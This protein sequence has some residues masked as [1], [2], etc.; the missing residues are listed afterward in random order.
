M[1]TP[2]TEFAFAI[3]YFTGSKIFNTLM[4][5]RAVEMGY[6]MNEHGIYH[7]ENKKKGKRIN[8][9]FLTE[10]SIFEFL[11]IE[12]R[13]PTERID[14]NSF[15]LIEEN[16]KIKPK[17]STDES[18]DKSIKKSTEKTALKKKHQDKNQIKKNILKFKSQGETFLKTLKEKNIEEMIKLLDDFYYGKNKPLVSD[19][20]YDVLRE[21]AE[22]TFP[23]N[24]V[25]KQGHE[26][27]VVDKKKVKLPYFL[28]SMDK[29]KPDTNVL[30]N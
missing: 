8:K 2:K 1:F 9:E 30:K 7:F 3:L 26:G 16:T 25:I 18:T 24:E 11:G 29:I 15:K 28:G 12:W 13:E 23:K 27:I 6:T 10:K 14:G 20:E 19:D 4:R 17:N 21:W 22:E 5:S